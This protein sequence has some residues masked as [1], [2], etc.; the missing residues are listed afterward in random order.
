MDFSDVHDLVGCGADEVDL[1][2]MMPPYMPP[3]VAPPPSP[4][5][6]PSTTPPAP[7]ASHFEDG[8]LDFDYLVTTLHEFASTEACSHLL[9][10]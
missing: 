2:R 5:G 10:G 3:A 9:I 1:I 4:I 7:W 8:A 6:S